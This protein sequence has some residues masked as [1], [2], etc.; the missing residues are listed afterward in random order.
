MQGKRNGAAALK[1][2]LSGSLRKGGPDPPSTSSTKCST[3]DNS[4][5]ESRF[6]IYSKHKAS[7]KKRDKS[8]A[9]KER[10]ATK[11]LAIVLGGYSLHMMASHVFQCFQKKGQKMAEVRK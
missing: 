3:K 7:R 4:T 5:K 2:V 11:T 6:T 8:A 1:R 9:R 10:K